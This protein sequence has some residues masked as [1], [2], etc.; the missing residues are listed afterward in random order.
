MRNVI[1]TSDFCKSLESP[2]NSSE[3]ALDP[4]IKGALSS[5]PGLVFERRPSRY[6]VRRIEAEPLPPDAVDAVAAWTRPTTEIERRLDALARDVGAERYRAW[7]DDLADA[8]LAE[9]YLP[10]VDDE[11]G[12]YPFE[13]VEVISEPLSGPECGWAYVDEQPPHDGGSAARHDG[14]DPGGGPG[15]AF[16][17]EGIARALGGYVG[18]ANRRGWHFMIAFARFMTITGLRWGSGIAKTAAWPFIARFAARP[19]RRKFT[20]N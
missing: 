7:L 5:H 20:P 10:P 13:I 1:D 2:E 18:H 11:L 16:D 14:D 6:P 4:A 12:E 8:S 9:R 3:N 19:G 15:R 17:A